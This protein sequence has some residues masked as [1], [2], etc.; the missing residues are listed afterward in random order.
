M[1]FEF[2]GISIR[3]QKKLLTVESTD[4]VI[5]EN[6]KEDSTVPY[7]A[8]L[9]DR[10]PDALM[11]QKFN[12]LLLK[13]K[14]TNFT[15]LYP[16]KTTLYPKDKI[17][18]SILD[19]FL[20]DENK[21]YEYIKGRNLRA[22]VVFGQALY[23][24]TRDTDLMAK[25][26]YDFI[27]DKTYFYH[28]SLPTLHSVPEHPT[29]TVFP[30]DSI[31][32]CFTSLDTA[33]AQQNWQTME[34]AFFI[35]QIHLMASTPKYWMPKKDPIKLTYINSEKEA[36]EFFQ[37]HENLPEVAW[38][39]ETDGFNPRKNDIICAT[40]AF[41]ENEAF[42]VPWEFIDPQ[43]MIK[44]L[45]SCKVR[46]GAN[47]KFDTKFIWTHGIKE[48][49]DKGKITYKPYPYCIYPTDGVDLLAHVLNTERP[50]GLK[51][52]AWLY[53]SVGGYEQKLD[54]Y[55]RK[56]RITN[57]GEIPREILKEYSSYDAVVTLRIFHCLIR[58]CKEIDR[59]FPNEKDPRFT[60]W[61]FYKER[62]TYAYP[63]WIDIEYEGVVVNKNKLME[64]KATIEKQ[65][66]EIE[67]KLL[68]IWDIP[69]E[70][71][72]KL[73]STEYL[74]KMFMKLGWEPVNLSK[75]GIY[76]TDIE[77]L[78]KWLYYERPGVEEM[79]HLRHLM[80]VL[81]TYIGVSNED[82]WA[83]AF[84][85][86][87]KDDDYETT[88]GWLA[89][90][91]FDEKDKLWKLYPQHR[92]AGTETFRDS[93]RNPNLQNLPAK[94]D[95]AGMVVSNLGSPDP[96]N[97]LLMTADYSSLQAR[98]ATQNTCWNQSGPDKSLYSIY[99]EG[100][101][102]DMHSTTSLAE[103]E[104]PLNT[105]AI[106]VEIVETGKKYVFGDK[107]KI[108]VKRNNEWVII[109][110]LKLQENDEIIDEELYNV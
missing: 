56:A 68:T 48:I 75:K 9:I 37:Q 95:L 81:K 34:T 6:Y 63:Q 83:D 18:G 43:D 107:Q 15:I 26:F 30:V 90:M 50:V 58:L 24:L 46:V 57:Y 78:E 79:I 80:Q 100:G 10:V 21:W 14:I 76:K 91:E 86:E 5:Q 87:D 22:L 32:F 67:T 51:V 8:F 74:G 42:Y 16:L 20:S 55:V 35:K 41:E 54:D 64:N 105:K 99:S 36:K 1:A 101:S 28:G 98:F 3:T 61:D 38:D 47:G 45:D 23:L 44:M 40:F 108:K 59:K 66:K 31:G 84:N 65:I 12:G 77:A 2:G 17:Q 49:D 104:I 29:T 52:L 102:E 39:L 25:H 13:E 106:E 62:I 97:V 27:T 7:Y 109:N 85:D 19:R 60:I 110:P 71:K 69:P 94:A 88:T 33:L 92:Y 70:D 82:E 11:K 93:C 96:E 4:M 89:V 53:T 72:K 73:Y 103:F